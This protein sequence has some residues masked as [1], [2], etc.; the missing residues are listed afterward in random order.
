[1]KDKSVFVTVGTTE[2]DQLIKSVTS[3]DVCKV[4]CELGYTKVLLQTGRG[5][6]QPQSAQ[7]SHDSP[8][9]QSYTFKDS[10]A[11][12]IAAADLVI[13]HAGAGS[14]LET[15]TAGKATLVVINDE[16]MDNHQEE[17]A[18]QLQQLHHLFYCTCSTLQ[19]TLKQAD[20][21]TLQR[22]TPGDP[23]FLTRHLQSLLR[24]PAAVSQTRTFVCHLCWIAMIAAVYVWTP[25]GALLLLSLILCFGVFVFFGNIASCSKE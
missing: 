23:A 1:M 5:Q 12:D 20:F 15:L 13:C 6:F 11:D 24:T 25:A 22:Y 10:I 2:F 7:L 9:V 19:Q 16:L 8:A 4:L 14:V 21:T 18:K 17:L 3:A